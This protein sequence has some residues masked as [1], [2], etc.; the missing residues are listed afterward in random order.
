ME[1]SYSYLAVVL[2]HEMLGQNCH[3]TTG[4]HVQSC[5]LLVHVHVVVPILLL[6]YL[7]MTYPLP[8]ATNLPSQVGTCNT[9][10]A[11]TKFF[12]SGSV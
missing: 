2:M 8:V 3:R 7:L 4:V 5:I 6:V 10:I 12:A 1:I 9:I 11:Q